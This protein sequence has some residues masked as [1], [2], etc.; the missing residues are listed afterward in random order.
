MSSLQK[1]FVHTVY[2]WLKE[3]DNKSHHEALHKG[4]LKLAENELIKTAFVGTPANTSR[5]V[6]DSTYDFSITFIFDNKED[7]DAYQVDPKHY[8][9]IDNCAQYWERVQVYDAES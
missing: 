5:E 7:Q 8:E 9:F 6:I 1:G 3:K 2:F 4:L